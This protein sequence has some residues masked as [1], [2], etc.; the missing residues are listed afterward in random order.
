[1]EELQE[2]TQRYI[3]VPDPTESA[4]RKQRVIEGERRGLMAETAANIL[5]AS[6]MQDHLPIEEDTLTNQEPEQD[7]PQLN[8]GLA[9]THS[10]N[11]KRKRGRPPLKKTVSNS[12][13]CLPGASSRK[14]KIHNL[15]PSP[16]VDLHKNLLD[17]QQDLQV[18][19]QQPQALRGKGSHGVEQHKGQL[20]DLYLSQVPL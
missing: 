6:L 16:N 11:N 10:E 3:N 18:G 7:L 1:M 20:L 15:R 2:V 19:D 17:N 4:A 5:A 13:H 9:A 12:P 14:R 8:M